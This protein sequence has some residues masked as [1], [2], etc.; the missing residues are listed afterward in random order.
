MRELSRRDALAGAT[1]LGTV[2]LAGC[3]S[4]GSDDDGSDTTENGTGN[5][6]A[7]NGDDNDAGNGD[8]NGADEELELLDTAFESAEGSCSS[9]TGDTASLEIEGTTLRINGTSP[10]PNPC[11]KCVLESATFENQSLS[12]AISVESTL[13]GNEAC[14]ECV[15]E[16]SY[17]ATCEF[18]D[19]IDATA[20]DTVTVEHEDGET[21][22]LVETG[23]VV[24]QSGNEDADGDSDDGSDDEESASVLGYQI[25][26]A[27]H[28]SDTGSYEVNDSGMEYSQTGDTVTIDGWI[29]TRTPCYDPVIYDA[30]FEDGELVV[31][32]SARNTAGDE[33]CMQV[34]SKLTYTAEVTLAAETELADVSVTYEEPRE[35]E[36]LD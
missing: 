13:E 15:G 35:M 33:A 27:D 17:E 25:Q 23:E 32:V 20:F 8:D 12:L 30:S 22:T 6:G 9:P 5:G 4:D 34:I 24:E 18:S 10:A 7:G 21:H 16:V 29:V 31:G 26:S 28:D 11:H 3:V 14:I 19:E 1:A 2:V 36:E